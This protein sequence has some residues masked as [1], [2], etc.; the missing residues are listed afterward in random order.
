M[1]LVYNW[2]KST[3]YTHMIY[4]DAWDSYVV[5]DY[6][7][8]ITKL[9]D[10]KWWGSV[11]KNC[12]PHP[13]LAKDYPSTE[14]DW[15]YVNGGGWFSEVDFFRKMVENNP[16]NRKNDQLWLAEVFLK[17]K[18]EGLPVGLDYNCEVFQTTGF[19]GPND[20][21]YNYEVGRI[22]NLKTGSLPMIF[23][24]NGRTDMSKVIKLEQFYTK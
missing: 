6:E 12:F 14:H 3:S 11:E 17:N 20:F 9:P 19:E 23:H 15:K 22:T 7:E 18:K 8:L 16:I 4:A 21:L 13:E 1:P 24:G 5:G 2:C 10:L